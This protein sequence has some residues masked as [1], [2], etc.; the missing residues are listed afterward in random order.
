VSDA[1]IIIATRGTPTGPN[2]GDVEMNVNGLLPHIDIDQR[3]NKM[4]I[5][6]EGKGKTR[7]QKQGRDNKTRKN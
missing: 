1:G 2:F 4:E 6:K 5:Q 7:A 3:D